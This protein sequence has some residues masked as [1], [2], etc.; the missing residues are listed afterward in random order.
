MF[1]CVCLQLK[2]ASISSTSVHY[3][4]LIILREAFG[5]GVT[6]LSTFGKWNVEVPGSRGD[7]EST[8][9]DALEPPWPP[10]ALFPC[11]RASR[12]LAAHGQSP[13]GA[14]WR[15][16]WSGMAVAASL[17]ARPAA[18]R[19]CGTCRSAARAPAQ[20]GPMS[21]SWH[22]RRSRWP[23]GLVSDLG[24]ASSGWWEEKPGRGGRWEAWPTPGEGRAKAFGIMSIFA[25]LKIVVKYT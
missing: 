20:R 14:T 13:P 16:T 4:I 17:R 15:R 23:W 7:D 21:S 9:W 24:W 2:N 11:F 1:Y 12:T 22:R 5:V 6:I 3:L 25:I 8:A 19:F 10:P 18:P